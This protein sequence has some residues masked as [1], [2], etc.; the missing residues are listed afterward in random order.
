MLSDKVASCRDPNGRAWGYCVGSWP[1]NMTGEPAAHVVLHERMFAA[2]ILAVAS[3]N[4]S[5]TPGPGRLVP[6]A[7]VHCGVGAAS[8][9]RANRASADAPT[10]S[11]SLSLALYRWI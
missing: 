2:A 3:A 5:C 9:A 8:A 10:R 1:T 6:S 4:G 7:N 11:R